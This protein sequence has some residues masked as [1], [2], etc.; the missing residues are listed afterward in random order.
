MDIDD[1]FMKRAGGSS[2]FAK[3]NDLEGLEDN[4]MDEEPAFNNAAE[5]VGDQP[6][7]DDSE[8]PQ[9]PF[10]LTITEYDEIAQRLESSL[11]SLDLVK[12]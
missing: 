9:P 4:P 2:I 7:I 8:E 3:Q 11:K 6:M 1:D 5:V 10:K 12:Q